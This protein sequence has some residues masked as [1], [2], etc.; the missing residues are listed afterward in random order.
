MAAAK[1]KPRAAST[2]ETVT[3]AL[4]EGE[5][6]TSFVLFKKG[7]NETSK[8]DFLFDAV[9]AKTVMAAHRQWGVDLAIDLEHQLLDGA[10]NDPTARDA[11]G[12]FQLELKKDGSLHAVDV[13]WTPDGAARLSARTQRYISPTFT[14][15]VES[16][17]ITQ[18]LCCALTAIPATHG[19]PALVAAD[20]REKTT[21]AE[22][23]PTPTIAEAIAAL[24][25]GDAARALEILQALEGAGGED[26][27]ALP[28]TELLRLTGATSKTAAVAEVR[29]WRAAAVTLER[30]RVQRA[31]ERAVLDKAERRKLCVELIKLGVEFPATVFDTGGTEELRSRWMNVPLEDLREHVAQQARIRGVQ[32][33]TT[34]DLSRPL[35]P[36][37]SEAHGRPFETAAGTITL[38]R[39]ELAH[40]EKKKIDPAKYAATRAAIVARTHQKGA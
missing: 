20:A 25:E 32:K 23:T 9:A 8:G 3:L 2:T 4:P 38:T 10:G 26:P 11:R 34:R 29:G 7:W 24:E 1:R 21:M 15:D 31:A 13:R 22:D 33:G 40:C 12:W 17:R 36:P 6:P 28:E 39:D 19:T 14:I 35:L 18:V 37:V 30:E 27:E 5:L 16:R